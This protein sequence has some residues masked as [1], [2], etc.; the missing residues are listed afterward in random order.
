MFL[1][2]VALAEGDPVPNDPGTEDISIASFD[3]GFLGFI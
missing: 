3:Q 2:K 1:S